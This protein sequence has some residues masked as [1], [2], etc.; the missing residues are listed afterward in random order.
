MDN[1]MRQNQQTS[2]H[3]I[4]PEEIENKEFDFCGVESVILTFDN[5]ILLQQRGDNWQRFPKYLANFGGQIEPNE[6]PIQALVRELHEELGAKVDALDV[7]NLGVITEAVSNHRDLV[8]VYFWHDKNHTITGCYEGIAKNYTS[9][10]EI[11]NSHNKIMDSVRWALE[12]SLAIG[13][14]KS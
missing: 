7:I 6:T 10:Q 8:Y 13:V 4:S 2:I 1:S 11:F 12:K 9:A 3:V 14:L 5:K